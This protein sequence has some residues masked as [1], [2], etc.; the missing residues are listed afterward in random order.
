MGRLRGGFVAD[1]I[2]WE[3]QDV[4]RLVRDWAVFVASG[5]GNEYV[6]FVGEFNKQRFDCAQHLRLHIKRGL[7][8]RRASRVVGVI[9]VVVVRQRIGR[10]CWRVGVADRSISG[11]S[12]HLLPSFVRSLR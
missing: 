2:F 9:A 12:F 8:T 1:C 6:D 3:E 7:K 5:C 10:C 11:I 4:G